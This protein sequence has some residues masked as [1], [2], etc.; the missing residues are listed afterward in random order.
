MS[1]HPAR[2]PSRRGYPHESHGPDPAKKAQQMTKRGK[3]EG[4]LSKMIM[5]QG[6][7]TQIL[8]FLVVLVWVI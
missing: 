5:T 7:I 2:N 6:G 8:C 4:Q 3:A 1:W